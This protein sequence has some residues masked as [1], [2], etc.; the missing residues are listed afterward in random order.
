M[1]DLKFGVDKPTAEEQ[2]AID[3]FISG[4]GPASIKVNERFV[5][6]GRSRAK[7]RRRLLLPALHELQSTS[8]WISPGGL[9]YICKVL[10]VPPAEAYGVATFYHLFSHQAPAANEQIHVCDDVACRLQGAE[11]LIKDL[12]ESGYEAKSSPCL[13]QCERGPA[14]LIQRIKGKDLAVVAESPKPLTVKNIDKALKENASS[15]QVTIP[16]R[17]TDSL[18]LLARVGVVNP[19]SIKEYQEKNGYEALEIALNVGPDKVIEEVTASKLS[20]RGGAAFPTGV[21][22]RAVADEQGR[23]R[24]IVCNADESE[25]GTFKDRTLMEGDPFAVIEAM[26]IAGFAIG[27]EQGWIYIRGEYPVAEEHL[28]NAIEEAKREGLLGSDISGSGFNFDISLYKGAG[29]YI[30]GEETALFNSIEGFRGEPRNKP[31]FPTTHGLFGEP[32]AINNV[33]TLVNVLPILRNGGSNYAMKGTENS[34]GTRL[35]CLSGRVKN[36]GIYEH[37]FGITLGEVIEAA[38]GVKDSKEIKAILLGGAAGSF[39]TAEHLHLPLTL[40][41]TREAGVSLGSGVVMVFDESDD[42]PDT[43]RRIAEFFRDESCGQCVPCRV[44]TV[45]QEEVLARFTQGTSFA[46]DEEL[47]EDL[48]TVMKDASIC[49]LGHTASGAI[50]SAI[51]LGLLERTT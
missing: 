23:P 11:E 12:K 8:G 4:V 42:L 25:P 50:T 6:G 15:E 44:G 45:R 22:W 3:D 17:G 33:E 29:A 13:G 18:S 36:P 37:E 20:G 43:I 34:P 16:Q 39:V 5:V 7:D 1:S 28:K 2:E 27:A 32:T 40:E 46:S 47:L 31:P 38:G 49:G 30:C 9:N 10:G 26:T 14:V 41:A 35:F 51:N 24:H 21:K 19:K 48:S